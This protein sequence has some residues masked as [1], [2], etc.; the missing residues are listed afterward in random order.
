[1]PLY[2]SL[3]SLSQTAA[4]NVADGSVDAPSTIDQQT[5]LLASFIAQLRDF[6]GFVGQL[7][8]ASGGAG[9]LYN[10][11][12]TGSVAVAPVSGAFTNAT[13]IIRYNPMGKTVLFN[14][15]VTIVT[16]GTAAGGVVVTMPFTALVE[17]SF[18]GRETQAT[19]SGCSASIAAGTSALQIF[20]YDNTYPGGSGYRISVNGVVETT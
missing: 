6:N 17:A 4:S 3:A 11:W 12:T 1:M 5:N 9:G 8:T 15:I 16:N 10:A 18:G 13:A 2:T 19:G 20:K 14:I 7:P